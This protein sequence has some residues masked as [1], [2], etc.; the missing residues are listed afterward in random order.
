MMTRRMAIATLAAAALWAS[1]VQA[2]ERRLT[3]AEAHTEA[4]AGRLILLDIRTPREWAQTGIGEGAVALSMH[5]AG[6]LEGLM[7]L[8]AGDRSRPLA[9]ICATGGRS[10]AMQQALERLGF[11]AVFD[12]PEGMMGSGAGPGWLRRGLPLSATLR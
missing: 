1:G 11:T 10:R 12:V 9:L 4:V 7:R 5:E 8:T 2:A 6:F 3:P